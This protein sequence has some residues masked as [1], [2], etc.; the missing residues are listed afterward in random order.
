MAGAEPL[1]EE[2]LAVIASTK[3]YGSN[4]AKSAEELRVLT[5]AL[6]FVVKTVAAGGRLLFVGSA[7]SVQRAVA[8]AAQ[9]SD[10]FSIN[11]EW[12]RGT[13]KKMRLL[14][15]MGGVAPGLIVVVDP[16][17]EEVA[18]REANAAGIPVLAIAG[19]IQPR[20]G[21]DFIVHGNLRAAETVSLYCNLVANA[22][23][24]GIEAK[25]SGD[26]DWKPVSKR[27]TE[28]IER[29]SSKETAVDLRRPLRW[30][31]FRRSERP[32]SGKIFD[33]ALDPRE[34]ALKI[35]DKFS[36]SEYLVSLVHRALVTNYDR[37]KAATKKSTPPSRELAE[38]LLTPRIMELFAAWAR[39]MRLGV[40][41]K[42]P[43]LSSRGF[44]YE[45]IQ[46]LSQNVPIRIDDG[47]EFFDRL[48]NE[49]L[50]FLRSGG[51]I[52][53]RWGSLAVVGSNIELELA[54]VPPPLKSNWQ[55]PDRIDWH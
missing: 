45:F 33:A 19:E 36:A 49:L 38:A 21:I 55:R 2:M 35:D 48:Q 52:G 10:Q 27:L 23:L 4:P 42:K 17:R 47:T 39:R 8:S 37:Q 6:D 14:A 24:L 53:G 18:I 43:I 44:D 54:E 13:L 50:T 34:V 20:E 12:P 32:V 41:S 7:P 29:L 28:R 40:L 11:A 3:S 51:R 9:R 1:M 5:S 31:F 15:R 22:A 25:V 30:S 46:E 26:L 16:D